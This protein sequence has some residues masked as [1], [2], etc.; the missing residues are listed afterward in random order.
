MKIFTLC[1]REA[2]LSFA[3]TFLI[4]GNTEAKQKEW[5]ETT[6]IYQVYPRS[7]KDSDGDGI[8]DLN[9]IYEK[10]DYIKDLGMEIIW[11][12]PFYRSPMDDLGYDV[13]NFN[14][15]EP[16]FG[17][18]ED[19]KRLVAGIH[20]RGMKVM[21]DMTPNHV[22]DQ[23]EWFNLS[24]NKVEPYKDYFIWRDSKGIDEKTKKQ[25]PPNNWLSVF[26]GSGWTW[27]EK[28]QQFYFRQFSAKQPDLNVRNPKVRQ[29]LDDVFVYWMDLG[30]DGFRVDAIRHLIESDNF[31]DEPYVSKELE[32][33][34]LYDS[35]EHI[36]TRDQEDTYTV[37]HEWRQ[38]MDEYSLRDNK[39]RIMV[40]EAY[41]DEPELVKYFGND[42]YKKTHFPFYFGFVKLNRSSSAK[43]LDQKTHAMIDLMP[44]EIGVANWVL[45]NHDNSRLASRMSPA[46]VDAMNMFELLL[47]GV[48]SVYY[49]DEIGMTDSIVR[50][51][52]SRDPQ[53][54]GTTDLSLKRDPERAPMQWDDSNNAGFTTNKTAWL[55]LSP[56]YYYRNVKKQLADPNSH[57]N[58]FK[59]IMGLRQSA[60]IQNGLLQTCVLSDWVYMYTR[61]LDGEPTVGV[62]VNLGSES[63]PACAKD[64]VQYFDLPDV[65]H[66]H[67]G[68]INSGYKPGDEFAL[69]S[70]SQCS[71]LR[72]KAG[73]VL[74]SGKSSAAKPTSI[75]LSSFSIILILVLCL[76]R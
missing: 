54:A 72:P 47:P 17:T 1:C 37:V 7:F 5:W 27:N 26:G 73:V 62:I 40:T 23:H 55:P 42:T 20:D 74:T 19:F 64:C 2:L 45:S 58:I 32:G 71:I 69:N 6:T 18:M 16:M 52:Q 67:T 33:S 38:L 10:L 13:A 35:M 39:T 76:F 21:L 70:D 75:F 41:C 12:Q 46:I 44:P 11:I 28:R 31:M 53:N 22:S 9:G 25:I 57:L 8:G 56:D 36:Y 34:I 61:K 50:Q 49:G 60:V 68:S 51:D 29:A 65:M 59:R 43:E 24:V 48:A 63:E 4:F 15:I 3:M 66:V 30:V 14:E